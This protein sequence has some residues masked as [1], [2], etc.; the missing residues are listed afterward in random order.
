MGLN[1]LVRSKGFKNF[2]AKLYGLGAA[3]VIVGALFKIQHYP[4]SGPMLVLGLGTE[5]VIFFFSAFEPPHVEP[6]W[7]LV[8]PE[9]AGM[10]S[11]S[12][13]LNINF[14]G[15]SVT[16]ELDNM[17][18]DAKIGPELIESLG[19]G[20]RSLSENANKL[21]DV[22]N[23][24][25]ATSDFV[26]NVKKASASAGVLTETYK[27]TADVLTSD[28]HVS[29]SY[30]SSVKQAAQSASQ[31]TD[32]YRLTAE[33]LKTDLGASQEYVE[34]IREATK[35]AKNMATKYS[36]SAESLTKQAE[37]IDFSG[38]DSTAY[39]EQLNKIAK[40]LSALNNVYELQ[41][42]A[43]SE[44]AQNTAQMQ[45]NMKQFLAYLNE[46]IENTA[47]YKDEAA[48]LAKNVAALNSVYGRMLSAMNV[49]VNN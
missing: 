24:A 7:S 6:D 17:L 44:Q 33:T 48:T 13:E 11:D 41:L 47:K 30:A 34:G 25:A 35:A 1:S 18:A 37:S 39:G 46:S 32:A 12:P 20:L 19:A 27:K 26:D 10:Y 23:A 45:D 42:Q 8:Y 15:G 14:S 28:A 43:S 3:V 22:S 38:I 40:N 29:E 36:E 5:A 31:L 2:M 16:Q 9:L 49:N 21:S 4:G